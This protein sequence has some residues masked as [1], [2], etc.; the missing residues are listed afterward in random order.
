[1]KKFLLAT[2]VISGSSLFAVL[3]PL[4]ESIVE[5]ETLLKDQRFAKSF[6]PSESIHEIMK[7]EKG[8]LVV[9][10]NYQMEVD[11]TYLPSSRPGP[12][13]FEL[14]FRSPV[15]VQEVGESEE[16]SGE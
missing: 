7:T 4:H 1:M 13:K 16:E 11:L 9:T 14:N 6:K 10:D 2:A 5:I 15:P 3:A 12:Q 8:Y